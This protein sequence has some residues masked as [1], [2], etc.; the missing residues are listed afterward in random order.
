MSLSEK[1]ILE[2]CRQEITSRFQLG[3]HSA[4]LKQRDFEYLSDL[5]AEKSGIRLSLSTLKRL[6]KQ[7]YQQNPHPAT[8]NAL[9]SLLDYQD[10]QQYKLKQAAYAQPSPLS[11][12]SPEE[13]ARSKKLLY[14]SLFVFVAAVI[15]I[16]LVGPSFTSTGDS[17]VKIKGAVHFE[18]NKTVGRGVPNTVVFAYDAQHIEADSFFIQQSWNP[19]HKDRISAEGQHFTSIYYYPGFHKAKLL[20]NDSIVKIKKVHIK[21]DGWLP[22]AIADYDQKEPNYISTRA[23]FENGQMAVNAANLEAA[24]VDIRQDFRLNY[25]YIED[26]GDV[27]S[28]NF[29][30]SARFKSDSLSSK[31]CPLMEMV[32]HCEKHIFF[33]PLTIA[34]CVSN[35]NLKLGENYVSGKHNDL[36]MLGTDVFQWQHLRLRVKDKKASIYLNQK[37]IYSSTFEQDHG[38]VVGISFR[39]GGLGSVDHVILEDKVGVKVFEDDFE[40]PF[41]LGF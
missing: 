12:D 34:G 21:T 19:L 7:D 1:G 33:V 5:I 24:Q 13:P 9:V 10:W 20:A 3:D 29:G 39:F 6:W 38:K 15:L 26:F 27:Y 31:A 37:H 30:L 41:A 28:D 4:R 32:V 17:A 18:A 11:T 36:S 8:L 22:Y 35:I 2:K 14:T 25:A 23:M 16:L 40:E